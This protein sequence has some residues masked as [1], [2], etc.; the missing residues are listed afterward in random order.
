MFMPYGA[1]GVP[2]VILYEGGNEV[3]R[4]DD[5]TEFEDAEMMDKFLEGL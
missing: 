3:H 4:V 1:Q 5:A 2:T